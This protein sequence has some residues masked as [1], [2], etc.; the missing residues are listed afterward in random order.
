MNKKTYE[1][2]TFWETRLRTQPNLIGVGHRRFSLKYNEGMYAVAAGNLKQA[3]ASAGINLPGKQVLDVGCG[4]GYFV[5]RFIEWG[6]DRVTGLDI[7]DVSVRTLRESFPDHRFIQADISAASVPVEGQFDIVSAINVIFHIVE[8]GKFNQALENLCT[9][10]KPNGHL[11]L[12]D[13]F[14]NSPLINASHAHHRTIRHYEPGLTKHGFRAPQI[15]PMYYLMG[16][17]F[18]PILGPRVLSYPP[19]L[20]VLLKIEHRL[21]TRAPL[22]LSA[23]QYLIAE[24]ASG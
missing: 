11:I 19:V 4:Y 6:A 17:S 1:A 21:N 8:D 5:K 3:L 23:L 15:Y 18:I 22:R 16:R 2:Q 13:A 14:Y 20:D 7:T 9:Y 10:V 24:R 12:V